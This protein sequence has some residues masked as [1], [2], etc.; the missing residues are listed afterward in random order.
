MKKF[1]K[2]STC[3]Y[4]ISIILFI[5]AC[6]PI[7]YV[8]NSQNVPLFTEKGEGRISASF[9]T[10]DNASGINFSGAHSFSQHFGAIGNIFL[11]G[12][13]G[14]FPDRKTRKGHL[15]DAGLVYFLPFGNIMV[16]ESTA[17][18]GGGA[19]TNRDNNDYGY[20]DSK[21]NFT[22][23]YLQPSIGLASKN[24]D[25][26]LSTKYSILSYHNLTIYSPQTSNDGDYSYP[27][28]KAY[29][30]LEPAITARV[31]WKH[32]KLQLQYVYRFNLSKA[33][34]NRDLQNFNF[35]LYFMLTDKYSR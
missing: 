3:L 10:S 31:G 15:I 27:D 8:P 22:N 16:F 34:L 23:F 35:G 11:V 19:A 14:L 4:F 29:S 17:G 26:A 30:L 18:F 32:V 5:N 21:V 7:Y 9:V 25:L 13:D 33:S 28:S 6:S 1:Y 24:F 20:G 12:V 2:Y